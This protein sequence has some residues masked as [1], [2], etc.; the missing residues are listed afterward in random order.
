MQILGFFGMYFDAVVV[1]QD[2]FNFIQISSGHTLCHGHN[3]AKNWG[4]LQ[5]WGRQAC[6]VPISIKEHKIQL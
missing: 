2:F 3:P 6:K 5:P 1:S 4:C